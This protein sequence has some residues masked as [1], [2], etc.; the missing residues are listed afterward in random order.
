MSSAADGGTSEVLHRVLRMI[1]VLRGIVD[2]RG[3][4]RK[5][6]KKKSPSRFLLHKF[7]RAV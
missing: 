7:M 1:R 3:D 4:T 6:S 2:A 5:D